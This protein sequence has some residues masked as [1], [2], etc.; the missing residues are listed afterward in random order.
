M[1]KKISFFFCEVG[2]KNELILTVCHA[3]LINGPVSEV[4]LFPIFDTVK[5]GF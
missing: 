2:C 5:Y 1:V 4:I 3:I